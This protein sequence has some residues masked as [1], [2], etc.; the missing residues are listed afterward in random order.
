ME[1]G[2]TAFTRTPRSA[3][4]MASERVTE[5]SPPLV[6]AASIAGTV[7]SLA[8]AAG[9][10]ATGTGIFLGGTIHDV[11]QVVGA[12]VVVVPDTGH[13][14]A[15]EALPPLKRAGVVWPHHPEVLA[16]FAFAA[17]SDAERDPAFSPVLPVPA[18]RAR[19]RTGRRDPAAL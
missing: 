13:S 12:R 3:N 7:L 15:A 1:P 14:P 16:L 17:A 9:L 11:A 5:L 18:Q 8:R 4:S 6:N 2:A 10:D 19:R